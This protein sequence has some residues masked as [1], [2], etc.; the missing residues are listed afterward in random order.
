[1][2]LRN[3]GFIVSN[4]QMKKMLKA[5]LEKPQ[6]SHPYVE[7]TQVSQGCQIFRVASLPK[8]P[9]GQKIQFQVPPKYVGIPNVG[10]DF[11][12]KNIPSGNPEFSVRARNKAR[13]RER[14]KKTCMT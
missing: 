12:Y 2:N 11:W 13:A 4:S 3:V 14:K 9:N 6:L 8:Q 7:R 10:V 5:H 1:M